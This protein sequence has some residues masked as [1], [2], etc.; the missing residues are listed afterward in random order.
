MISYFQA[1]VLGILQGVSEPFPISSL[2]H[3]VIVPKLFGWNLSQSNNSFVTFLVATHFATA[4][5]FLGLFW[6][7][8]V[9]I[10]RGLVRSIRQRRLDP[11]DIDARLGWLLVIATVPAGIV[12]LALQHSLEKLF[13]NARLV[14]VI[15]ILNGLMLLG[16][17]S[18]RQRAHVDDE[19][20]D[21]RLAKGLTSKSAFSIGLAQALALIP[22]FSRS[23]AS[24]SGGLLSGLSHR[25]AARFSFLLATPIIAAAALLKLPGLFG[26]A[27]NGIRGQALVGA[28]FA[29]IAAW[30]SVRFLLRFFEMNRL[31]PF[32]IYCIVA[33]AASLVWLTLA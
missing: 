2:G 7:D 29:A 22:G 23:G 20:E 10:I 4:L 30:L 12:G 28:I 26:S 8:W 14:A 31:T 11:D 15:L 13:G 19:D 32:G 1:T 9:R 3:S 5:V 17:E 25:D 27:G 21:A 24:M 18:L 16:A 33:G 6:D